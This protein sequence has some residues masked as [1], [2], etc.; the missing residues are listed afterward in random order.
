MVHACREGLVTGG[1]SVTAERD[2]ANLTATRASQVQL[3]RA[4]VDQPVCR[5][6]WAGALVC[7]GLVGFQEDVVVPT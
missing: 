2:D 4:E 1:M 7:H 3:F 5:K 6:G